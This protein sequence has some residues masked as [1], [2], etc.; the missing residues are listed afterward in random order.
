MLLVLR[1]NGSTSFWELMYT[2][3]GGIGNGVAQSTTFVQLAAGVKS[4]EMAT[5]ATSLYL[6]QN[7]GMI[8]GFSVVTFVLQ[9]SL[10]SG[11]A[12]SLHDIPHS[13]EVSRL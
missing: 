9:S 11:L 6:S 8:S 5:A 4:S 7:L 13:H 10:R 2:I 12:K 3:P 1:W